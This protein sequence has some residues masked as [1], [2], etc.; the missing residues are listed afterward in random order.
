V[1]EAIAASIQGRAITLGLA[2][3]GGAIPV[4][5]YAKELAIAGWE[6]AIALSAG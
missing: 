6:N 2:G 4:E 1:P 3:V 5:S